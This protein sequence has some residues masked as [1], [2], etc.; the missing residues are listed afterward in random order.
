MNRDQKVIELR[1][2]LAN[3]RIGIMKMDKRTIER[4]IKYIIS[5]KDEEN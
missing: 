3:N 2:H 1:E 4:C 5:D